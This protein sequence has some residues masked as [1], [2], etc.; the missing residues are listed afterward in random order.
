D[1]RGLAEAQSEVIQEI[2]HP[3]GFFRAKTR[4]VQKAAKWLL[5]NGGVP[6][7]M[8]ELLKIPGVGRKTANVVLGEAFNRPA[9]IVDTH[10][11]RLSNR[12]DLTRVKQPDR[13][14]FKLRELLPEEKWTSFSH[15][16][17]F[18]GRRI[19]ASRNPSCKT[20]SLS[21]ICPKRGVE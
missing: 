1:I 7:Q 15:Q 21:D 6:N 13:I 19:C 18:H 20:C 11:K 17:G 5:K 16:L 12:L 10:V 2:V 9:I 4:S 3:L 8:Q 14:E